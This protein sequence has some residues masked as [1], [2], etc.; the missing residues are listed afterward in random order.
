MSLSKWM[1][2]R[3]ITE[4]QSVFRATR[5]RKLSRAMIAYVLNGHEVKIKKYNIFRLKLK[6]PS[7]RTGAGFS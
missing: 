6:F 3:E 5:D 7:Y 4:R 2:L 1:G